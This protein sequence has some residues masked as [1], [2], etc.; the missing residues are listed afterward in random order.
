[1]NDLKYAIESESHLSNCKRQ[2]AVRDA[3]LVAN[4]IESNEAYNSIWY[5]KNGDIL[6]DA[7]VAKYRETFD[8]IR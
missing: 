1:M 4:Y 2:K 8:A 7:F 5:E 6:I 3:L